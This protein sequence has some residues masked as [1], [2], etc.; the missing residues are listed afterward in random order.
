[1][2]ELYLS[3]HQTCEALGITDADWR[4]LRRVFRPRIETIQPRRSAHGKLSA[5]YA[6]CDVIAFA[7]TLPGLLSVEAELEL[8]EVAT[9]NI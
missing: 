6:L 2:G 3:S 5:M 8:R 1:M 9:P 7:E 4:C